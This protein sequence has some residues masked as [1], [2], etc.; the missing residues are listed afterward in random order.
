MSLCLAGQIVGKVT[1][2]RQRIYPKLSEGECNETV[3]THFMYE[4]YKY[5][6]KQ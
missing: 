2:V 6:N 4:T 3:L 5:L 1:I